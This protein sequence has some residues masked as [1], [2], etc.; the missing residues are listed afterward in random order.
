MAEAPRQPQPP[1]HGGPIRRTFHALIAF[2]GWVLFVY[3]W[4]IVARRVSADEVRFTALF[5]GIALVAIVGLTAIWALHN[6]R[7]FKV[8]GPRRSLR[9]VDDDLSHDSVGREVLLPTLPEECRTAPV[10]AVRIRDGFKVYSAGAGAPAG[11]GKPA[12]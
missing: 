1:V 11:G 5:I 9:P 6:V 4:W 12:P 3:W 8:R 7:I 2:A 10:V